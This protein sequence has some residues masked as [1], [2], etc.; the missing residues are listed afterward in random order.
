MKASLAVCSA[1]LALAP[2]ASAEVVEEETWYSAEGKVVKTVKRTLTGAEA[3]SKPDW[4]PA[5]IQRE[6]QRGTRNYVTYSSLRRYWRGNSSYGSSYYPYSSRYYYPRSSFGYY[7]RLSF[8]AFNGRVR[9]HVPLH[10]H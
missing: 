9:V 5:W 1:A 8:S 6:R 7:N 2:I 4:E 10:R 3:Q